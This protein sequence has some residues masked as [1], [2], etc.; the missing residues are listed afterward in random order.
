MSIENERDARSNEPEGAELFPTPEAARKYVAG[1][2]RNY[3]YGEREQSQTPDEIEF[4]ARLEA[5][6]GDGTDSGLIDWGLPDF[7]SLEE[8]YEHLS[9]GSA[10]A[11]KELRAKELTLVEDPN[12]GVFY[13]FMLKY[14]GYNKEPYTGKLGRAL[15]FGGYDD[16]VAL[17]IDSFAQRNG[18][19]LLSELAQQSSEQ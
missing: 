7:S 19:P 9:S 16:Y 3:L 15:G 12:I 5:F 13:Y 8:M 11:D 17:E 4:N 10:P 6:V 1:K 18:L 2:V 14:P